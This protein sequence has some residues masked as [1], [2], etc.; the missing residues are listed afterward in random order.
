MSRKNATAVVDD[1]AAIHRDR[2]IRGH[3]RAEQLAATLAQDITVGLS[4][5]DDRDNAIYE[6]YQITLGD[7]PPTES[8]DERHGREMSAIQDA[9]WLLGVAAGRRLVGAR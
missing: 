9:A 7:A 5:K 2:L 1:P 3:A 4:G 8:E 6:V